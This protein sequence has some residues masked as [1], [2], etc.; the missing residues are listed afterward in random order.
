MVRVYI[1]DVLVIT[2]YDFKYHIKSLYRVIKI[3]TE[4]GLKL[5]AE[6][7]FFGKIETKYIGFWLSN[8]LLRLLFPKVESIKAIGVPNKLHNI[9]RFV[10]LVSYCR[11]M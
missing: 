10:R 3:L 9:R 5:N 8:N 11:D 6:K 4:V 7:S 2:K 1:Y